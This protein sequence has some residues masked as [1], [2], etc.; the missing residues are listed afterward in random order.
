MDKNET[1]LSHDNAR[2]RA[3]IEQLR[4][5]LDTALHNATYMTAKV[6]EIDT[7]RLALLDELDAAR[8]RERNIAEALRLAIECIGSDMYYVPATEEQQMRGAL[9]AYDATRKEHGDAMQ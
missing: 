7:E 5:E 6:A 9:A 8:E 4:R 1:V 2:L 3:E